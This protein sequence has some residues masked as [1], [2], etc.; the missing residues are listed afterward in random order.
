MYERKINTHYWVWSIDR[1]SR[2]SQISV[3]DLSHECESWITISRCLEKLC[4]ENLLTNIIQW[5]R[6]IMLFRMMMTLKNVIIIKFKINRREFSPRKGNGR[7]PSQ[8]RFIICAPTM[9]LINLIIWSMLW[10]WQ[11]KILWNIATLRY[12]LD[13]STED[14]PIDMIQNAIYTLQSDSI[15]PEEDV[16]VHFARQKFN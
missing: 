13:V 5:I 16:I 10:H 14:I 4:I 1:K 3:M 11:S 12:K 6:Y 15:T 8:P 7:N 9:L 2:K